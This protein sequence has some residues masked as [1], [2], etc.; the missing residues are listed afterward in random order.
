MSELSN[1]V[2]QIGGRIESFKKDI[3]HLTMRGINSIG[4]IRSKIDLLNLERDEDLTNLDIESAKV[5]M[6]E[7][8]RTI[9]EMKEVRQALALLE[10]ELKRI[11]LMLR[12]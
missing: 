2:Y 3:R 6:A 7:L 8:D 1:S 10:K 5:E 9:E 4:I 12:D 11:K